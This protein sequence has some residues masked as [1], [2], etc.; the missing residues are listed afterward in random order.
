M[1]QHVTNMPSYN[2]ATIRVENR[3]L[4][5]THLYLAFTSNPIQEYGDSTS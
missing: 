5:A 2:L 1:P 3:T 4:C